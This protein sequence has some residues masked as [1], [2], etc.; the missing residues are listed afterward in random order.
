MA[1]FT[2]ELYI[3]DVLNDRIPTGRLTRLAVERHVND[4]KRQDTEEFP[5]YFSP[6]SAKRKI[7]FSQEMRYT[8][9]E[10]AK[11]KLKITLQ[12]WQQFVDW[13]VYGWLCS[14]SGVRRF[15]KAYVEVGR[16]N[17]KTEWKA[18]DANYCLTL[19]GEEGAE[20][21]F[22]A[23]K[24]DQAKIA[25]NAA[26]IQ[27]EKNSFLKSN[28]D[29]F[30]TSSR[31]TFKKT[32][33]IMLPVGQDSD[34]E[35]GLNPSF[36]L[37]DEYHAHKDASLL[38]VMQDGMGARSQ[39]ILWIITTAG[40]DKSLPCFQEERT[41]VEGILDG[42]MD[43]RPEN[44][45][46]IIYTL[47]EGDDWTDETVWI[48]SN[49]NLGVSVKQDFLRKQVT[50][51][52]AS[53]QKQNNVLTKH[54][55]I[56]TQAVSRWISA[57]E[58]DANVAPMGNLA[59]RPCYAGLDLSTA[60]DITAWVLCFPPTDLDKRFSFLYRFFIPGD[61]LLAR[62]RRDKV[63]YTLWRDRGYITVTDGNV[64]D[65]EFIEAQIKKDADDYDLRSIAYDPWNSTQVTN[66][67]VNEMQMIQFRQG[68]GSM[69][70]PSKDFEKRILAHEL[71]H[72]GNPVM[73]WMVANTEIKTDAAGNIKP[74]K[75]DRKR[76]GKRIDGV[77]GSIMALD[78]AVH[79]SETSVYSEREV[80]A[81]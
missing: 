47:D 27:C 9:G 16:K 44:V 26:R 31:I 36:A 17:G 67:L 77:I 43:P 76:T 40:F 74:V 54:F 81:L 51:A 34:T 19:D 52:L 29:L 4:L 63:P 69:S 58:W 5:Y 38:N 28:T 18:T 61:D 15:T 1:E 70:A 55:N 73:K 50:E 53:P 65:Y 23:T 3:D 49:P 78:R 80:L 66:N 25:W 11:Q 48:K 7:K 2:A 42:T 14:G 79:G 32:N 8:K 35:D 62:E 20:V 72:G 24:R 33:S 22:A 68:F 39:P 6:E 46:G 45:F 12:P 10:W 64:V 37:I 56:W 30:K 41:L 60:V 21:Y 75:P 57:E 59:G 71:N 13:V